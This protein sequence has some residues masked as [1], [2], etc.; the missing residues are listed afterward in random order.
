MRGVTVGLGDPDVSDDIVSLVWQSH[1][2]HSA[3]SD[4][5]HQE[6]NWSL[7]ASLASTK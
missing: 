1:V 5:R 6:F 4:P 2:F 3:L 7:I